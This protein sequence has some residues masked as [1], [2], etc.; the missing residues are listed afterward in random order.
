M[1]RYR[2]LVD[3][4]ARW[5]GFEF[6]AGDIVITT[7]KKCG[8]TWTQMLCALLIFDGPVFPE[9]LERL[10]PWL[11]MCNRS[12]DEV[13]AALAGQTHRR[14]IKTHTPLDGAGP[15]RRR[16]VR[17]HRPGPARRRRLV[18]APREEHGLRALPRA[19]RRGDGQRRPRPVPAAR[20]PARRPGGAVS[21]VRPR[22][23]AGR[24]SDAR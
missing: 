11:D 4:S 14:F 13:R 24:R 5:D 23:R 21:L 10:S 19:A 2:S 17:G 8:T 9:P 22:R 3:D 20:G 16:H 15:A 1:V 18:R 12:I 7:P 6:R